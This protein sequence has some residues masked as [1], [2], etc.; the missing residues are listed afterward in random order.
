[1]MEEEVE[2]SGEEGEDVDCCFFISVVILI[3]MEEESP[4]RILVRP[5]SIQSGSSSFGT[6]VTAAAARLLVFGDMAAGFV[7]K[8]DLWLSQ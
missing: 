7:L 2:S 1:M 3:L 5:C 6:W 4:T 8:Y